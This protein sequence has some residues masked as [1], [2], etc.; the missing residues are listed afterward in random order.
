MLGLIAFVSPDSS[1]ISPKVYKST[2]KP[3]YQV[4]GTLTTPA[5]VTRSIGLPSDA[6][7]VMVFASPLASFYTRENFPAVYRDSV[8]WTILS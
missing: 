1:I 7:V 4:F 6:P 2:L 5:A 8:I 3:T